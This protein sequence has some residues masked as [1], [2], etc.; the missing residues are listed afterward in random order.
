[1]T[2]AKTAAMSPTDVRRKTVRVSDAKHLDHWRKGHVP[3]LPHKEEASEGADVV[4]PMGWLTVQRTGVIEA[5]RAFADGAACRVAIAVTGAKNPGG[6]AESGSPI[7]MEEEIYRCSDIHRH[8]HAYLQTGQNKMYELKADKDAGC[9]A[10]FSGVSYIR[11]SSEFGYAF[12]DDDGHVKMDTIFARL[13]D[14]PEQEDRPEGTS[15]SWDADSS[16]RVSHYADESN[17]V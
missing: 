7:G 6:K 15:E 17:F 4:L 8:L 16:R 2:E 3:E 1:M 5:G 14:S 13:L 12:T 11:Q 10:L 9:A